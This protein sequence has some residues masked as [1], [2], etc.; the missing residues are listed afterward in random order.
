LTNQRLVLIEGR[1]SNQAIVLK[2]I[3]ID[4]RK[5]TTR[6]DKGCFRASKLIVYKITVLNDELNDCKVKLLDCC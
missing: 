5:N 2:I 4:L 1:H 3:A 6:I